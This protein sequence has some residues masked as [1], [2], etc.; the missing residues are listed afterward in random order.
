MC[1]GNQQLFSH[2]KQ[3]SNFLHTV[4]YNWRSVDLFS[5]KNSQMRTCSQGYYWIS[6]VHQKFHLCM[7]IKYQLTTHNFIIS[8]ERASLSSSSLFFSLSA[9]CCPPPPQHLFSHHAMGRKH[10]KVRLPRQLKAGLTK[11]LT[12]FFQTNRWNS[13]LPREEIE[14]KPITFLQPAH[15]L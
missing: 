1:H 15:F 10:I 4:Q 9:W 2:K 8:Q 3:G 13:L 5:W 11:A 7:I 12:E 14:D 6:N